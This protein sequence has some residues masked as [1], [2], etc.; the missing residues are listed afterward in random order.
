MF[1]QAN[2]PI[3]T[4]DELHVTEVA[5]FLNFSSTSERRGIVCDEPAWC[6]NMLES[7]SSTQCSH[8]SS[9]S[10]GKCSAN[11]DIGFGMRTG[12]RCYV[13]TARARSFLYHQVCNSPLL[14]TIGF[15]KFLFLHP[16]MHSKSMAIFVLYIFI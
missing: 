11:S 10:I 16:G 13:I 4:L 5:S 3:R 2:S 15:C 7:E 8:V 12:H 14:L 1:A 9:T 6:S